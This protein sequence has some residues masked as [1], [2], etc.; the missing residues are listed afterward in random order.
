M[1]G[2]RHLSILKS[3]ELLDKIW[4]D[5]GF[6]FSK[7]FDQNEQLLA[8]FA[9]E[10]QF[11]NF[12]NIPRKLVLGIGRKSFLRRR[13]L[14]DHPETPKDE[15]LFDRTETLHAGWIRRWKGALRREGE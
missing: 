7:T 6:G 12:P 8:F 10:K 4:W 3:E 2:P 14:L 15:N 11:E 13:W 9:D 1:I 5:P